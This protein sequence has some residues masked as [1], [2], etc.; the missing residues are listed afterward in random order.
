M[1]KDK[2]NVCDVI[3]KLPPRNS[4]ILLNVYF[5]IRNKQLAVYAAQ[6][7]LFRRISYHEMQLL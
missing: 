5:G 3:I 4:T 1:L 7:R 2:L 6:G